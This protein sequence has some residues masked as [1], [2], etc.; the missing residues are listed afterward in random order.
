[1][2]QTAEILLKQL[3]K[4]LESTETFSV[5]MSDAGKYVETA[6]GATLTSLYSKLFHVTC[7]ARLLRNNA[8]K[9]KSHFEDVDQLIAKPNHQ[10]SKTTPNKSNSLLVFARLCLLLQDGNAD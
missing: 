4:Q 8:M 3:A 9:V 10:L 7:V 5:L 6:G 1:M 2:C